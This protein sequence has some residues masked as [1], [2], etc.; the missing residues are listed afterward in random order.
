MSVSLTN[1]FLQNARGVT[2]TDANGVTWSINKSTNS[3]T[4]SVSGASGGT[5]TSVGL[6]DGSANPI[7]TISGSPVSASGT[8]SF[9]LKAQN[10]NLVF[11][12]PSSG[13]AAQPGFRSLV[14]ADFPTGYKNSPFVSF[15]AN[16]TLALADTGS[17]FQPGAAALTLTIP[18]N[19]SVA[20]PVGTT[21][22][23][24][25]SGNGCSI[26]ITTDTLL[27]LQGGSNSTGTRTIAAYS[28][29]KLYKYAS[30][31]WAI[32]GNGVS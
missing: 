23:M 28:W 22:Y 6:S 10:S 26:A 16:Y 7:Y 32:F 1:N 29:V 8:L 3:I 18:A 17:T 19:G 24:L 13:A 31:V 27:W 30:T 11:A 5:V 14:V 15:A 9:A 2:L 21:I 25:T 12:G 20:F 4:A